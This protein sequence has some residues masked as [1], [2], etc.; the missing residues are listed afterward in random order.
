MDDCECVDVFMCFAKI[1][2]LTDDQWVSMCSGVD[3]CGGS[4]SPL[5]WPFWCSH[6]SPS[7]DGDFVF[8][9]FYFV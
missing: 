3:L 8:F 2:S 4:V 6:Y 5:L 7:D 9:V 1:L